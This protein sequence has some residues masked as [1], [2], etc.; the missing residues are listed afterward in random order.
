MLRYFSVQ[1]YMTFVVTLLVIITGINISSYSLICLLQ[2]VNDFNSEETKDSIRFI[3]DAMVYVYGIILG[4]L[5]ELITIALFNV[6]GARLGNKAKSGVLGL[7][8]KKVSGFEYF[9]KNNGN[10]IFRI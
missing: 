4:F 10:D 8:Y 6:H 2:L 1:D 9:S 7:V 3:E 5:M